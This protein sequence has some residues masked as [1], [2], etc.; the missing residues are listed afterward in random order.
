ML[1]LDAKMK[2]IFFSDF[3]KSTKYAA[4]FSKSEIDIFLILENPQNMLQV[5]AKLKEMFFTDFRKSTKYDATFSKS[6]RNIF[7]DFRKS[8]KYAASCY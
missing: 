2:E 7:I 1:Q 3:K 6:E 8:T 5:V 4:T